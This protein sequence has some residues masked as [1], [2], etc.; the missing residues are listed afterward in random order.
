MMY[1]CQGRCLR[2]SVSRRV[3]SYLKAPTYA[4]HQH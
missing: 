3:F 1:W 4:R 2:M